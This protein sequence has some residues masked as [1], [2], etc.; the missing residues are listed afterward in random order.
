MSNVTLHPIK[1]G[2]FV[3]QYGFLT[4]CVRSVPVRFRMLSSAWVQRNG[5]LIFNPIFQTLN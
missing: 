1:A 4:L 5:A 3:A 2:R